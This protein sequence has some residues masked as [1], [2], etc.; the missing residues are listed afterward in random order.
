[1]AALL[2]VSW[3]RDFLWQA[4][5]KFPFHRKTNLAAI[6]MTGLMTALFIVLTVLD[7]E[8]QHQAR[9]WSSMRPLSS[10]H[11]NL[12]A[13][14]PFVPPRARHGLSAEQIPK[15]GQTLQWC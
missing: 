14:I 8:P 15:S 11:G 9:C 13:L 6:A 12:A 2:Q 7:R 1:M 3:L 10:F 5:G 4:D